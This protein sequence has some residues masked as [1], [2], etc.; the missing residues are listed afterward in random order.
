MQ[1]T[2]DAAIGENQSAAIKNRTI[3]HTFCTFR[4]VIDVTN[5]LNTNL[6]LIPLNFR[7]PTT[8]QSGTSCLL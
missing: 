6:S 3:L 4:D 5:K 7:E 2:A 8:E 1:K